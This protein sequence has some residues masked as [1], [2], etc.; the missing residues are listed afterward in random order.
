MMRVVIFCAYFLGLS[1]IG[2]GQQQ[3]LYSQYLNSLFALNPA[4]AGNKDN[5]QGLI[6]ERRQW[7]AI[8]G[9]PHSQSLIFH[10]PVKKQKMGYGISIFNET[11]GAHG[12]IG[13][14]GS[15]SYSIKTRHS[16]LSFGLRAGGYNFRIDASRMN[17]RLDDDPSALTNLQSNFTPTFDAGIHYYNKRVMMGLVVTNLSETR[18]GFVAENIVANNLT[19]HGYGYVGYVI[20]LSEM[21]RFQPSLMAK[22][23]AAAPFNMDANATFIYKA[24]VGL[25]LSYRTSN[26]IVAIAQLFLGKN[27]RIGYA[28]DYPTNVI[29]ASA[30]GG[31][32]EVFL[33]FDLN[34][35]NPGLVNPRY[36]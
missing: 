33:G 16:A 26:S 32:H 13:I 21:W 30:L 9:S 36:L 19:R 8:E 10:A 3:T 24:K 34:K 7:T 23:S 14:F 15:Y 25:G 4:Y 29:R 31:S 35:K 6:T 17:Y 20:D 22:V 28:F 11:I 27:F 18:I 5:I 2:H 12:V 1:L